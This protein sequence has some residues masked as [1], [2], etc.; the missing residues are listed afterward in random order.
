LNILLHNFL[1]LHDLHSSNQH[2]ITDE[3]H[4]VNDDARILS[5][6]I[7]CLSP[8]PAETAI[9]RSLV[10]GSD[11]HTEEWLESIEI[12]APAVLDSSEVGELN[13][14]TEKLKAGSLLRADS[15]T[16]TRVR[17]PAIMGCRSGRTMG[18]N[19]TYQQKGDRGRVLGESDE[20]R[21][22]RR[23]IEKA[24]GE[25]ERAIRNVCRLYGVKTLDALPGAI[26]VATLALLDASAD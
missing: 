23:A 12:L 18:A 1:A 11:R 20:F 25:R 16:S 8:Y 15:L 17:P 22:L 7:V 6:E 13:G 19:K 21:H 5:L 4:F 3:F 2:L 14:E 9:R 24:A 26:R 10:A